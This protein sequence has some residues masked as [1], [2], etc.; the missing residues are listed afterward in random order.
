VQNVDTFAQFM[1]R[2]WREDMVCTFSCAI[3]EN[4]ELAAACAKS[5]DA[6]N[7]ST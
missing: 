1:V 5:F 2:N 6:S 3:E 4:G 7:L